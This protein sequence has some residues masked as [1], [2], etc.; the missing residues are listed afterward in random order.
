M[1]NKDPIK[2]KIALKVV[3]KKRFYLIAFCNFNKYGIIWKIK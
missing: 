2:W 3:L 1:N